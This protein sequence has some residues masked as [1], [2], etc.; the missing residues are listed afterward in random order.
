MV[1]GEGLYLSKNNSHLRPGGT[2]KR[3]IV[4]SYFLDRLSHQC[5]KMLGGTVMSSPSKT[6]VWM[7]MYW[8]DY[9]RDTGHLTTTE[10]GAKI[11]H[12]WVTGKPLPDD[13]KRLANIPRWEQRSGAECGKQSATSLPFP[14]AFGGTSV[15]TQSY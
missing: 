15:S 3:P 1:G 10:H 6:T 8:G 2:I 12:Y 13:D 4:S 14:M 9:L 7:P 11:G 5:V